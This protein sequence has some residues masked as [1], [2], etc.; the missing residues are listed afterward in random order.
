MWIFKFKFPC[1]S[2][3][4]QRLAHRT[5]LHIWFVAAGWWW[6]ACWRTLRTS[7]LWEGIRIHIHYHEWSDTQCLCFTS[8]TNM[9]LHP[10][11]SSI[12]APYGC[13]LS[14]LTENV[15]DSVWTEFF[16]FHFT[17]TFSM[18]CGS[19]GQHPPLYASFKKYS[20]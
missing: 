6:T 12:P 20:L 3:N 1:W 5:W 19:D 11:L 8:P 18:L 14:S 2:A 4:P 17:Q 10:V 7:E 16:V 15:Q 13:P 9:T